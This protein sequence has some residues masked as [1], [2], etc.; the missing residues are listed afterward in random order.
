MTPSLQRS[1]RQI[2]L[3]VLV[4]FLLTGLGLC[5]GAEPATI[6]FTELTPEAKLT[7]EQKRLRFRFGVSLCSGYETGL[8]T[9]FSPCADGEQDG[10]PE[11]GVRGRREG[12]G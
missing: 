4:A 9:P 8:L 5:Q 1:K 7:T 3:V 2:S 12:V 11:S 10:L 6:S